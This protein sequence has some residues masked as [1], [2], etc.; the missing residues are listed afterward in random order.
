MTFR[1]ARNLR[2]RNVE[3]VWEGPAFDRW[4]SALLL[5]D[6][7]GLEVRGFAGRQAGLAGGPAVVLDQVEDAVIREARAVE[8]TGIFLEV[9]GDRSRGIAVWGNDV[10]QAAVTLKTSAEVRP[11]AVIVQD[12][13]AKPG[14]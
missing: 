5:E 7:R 2:L 4:R 3:I 9:R 11:G 13:L 12:N 6:I 8:G 14:R 1:L 10:R